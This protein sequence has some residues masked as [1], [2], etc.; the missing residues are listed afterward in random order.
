MT[1]EEIS[2]TEGI[3]FQ[4][5]TTQNILLVINSTEAAATSTST[6]KATTQKV[7][8]CTVYMK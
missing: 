6:E 3:P 5:F 1:S 4:E 7:D 2:S 8:Q